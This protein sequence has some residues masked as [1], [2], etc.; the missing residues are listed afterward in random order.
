MVQMLKELIK[1]LEQCIPIKE[2]GYHAIEND[3]LMPIYKKNTTDLGLEQWKEFHKHNPAYIRDN[4]VLTTLVNTKEVV[5]VKN[6]DDLGSKISKHFIALDIKSIYMFPMIKEH[7]VIGF[8]DIPY[9]GKTVILTDEQITKCVEI[10]EKY[11]KIFL[12]KNLI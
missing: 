9:M 4:Y 2:I 3:K 11:N 8:I 1:E 10:V 7:K 5:A 6:T 12:E